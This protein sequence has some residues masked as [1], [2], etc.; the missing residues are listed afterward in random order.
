[1]TEIK[2]FR[3]PYLKEPRKLEVLKYLYDTFYSDNLK[4]ISCNIV[5]EIFEEAG[6]NIY[7]EILDWLMSDINMKG[8]ISRVT[9]EKTITQSIVRGQ[10]E[11]AKWLYRTF[12]I[13]R[14]SIADNDC[15]HKA[16]KWGYLVSIEW[17][18]NTFNLTLDELTI[19]KNNI[20]IGAAKKGHLK[21]LKWI[22]STFNLSSEKNREHVL[23][24][25]GYGLIQAIKH[26]KIEVTEWLIENYGLDILS[27]TG[28]MADM[29]SEALSIF[30]EKYGKLAI[31]I[32]H[33]IQYFYNKEKMQ[34]EIECLRKV[35]FSIREFLS[36]K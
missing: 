15:L 31:I 18:Y 36:L 10:I 8:K 3:Q 24:S 20:I 5:E 28:K 12:E 6:E 29:L 1:M 11:M 34:K 16:A 26:E 32:G 35:P 33:D 14:K 4:E 13:S 19:W 7:F 30:D 22:H 2:N 17:A 9:I 21:I 25:L 23:N 27:L